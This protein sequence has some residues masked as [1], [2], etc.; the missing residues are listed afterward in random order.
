[1]AGITIVSGAYGYDVERPPGGW[2]FR[3]REEVG[4]IYDFARGRLVPTTYSASRIAQ[5]EEMHL[6]LS[7]LHRME[8]I[9]YRRLNQWEP[10]E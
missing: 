2:F 6:L 5:D 9:V 8:L 4:E 10:S 7:E 3:G 1:M